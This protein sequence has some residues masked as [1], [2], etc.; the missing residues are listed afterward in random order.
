MV[1]VM[2]AIMILALAILPMAGMFDTALRAAVLG[3]N[4]DKARA[5]ANEKLEEALA[6]PYREPGGGSDSVI[7]VPAGVSVHRYRGDIHLHRADEVPRRRLL[8]PEQLVPDVADAGRSRGPVARVV[9]HHRR[10]RRRRVA[11]RDEDGFTFPE[12]LVATTLM[13]V[14]LFALYSIFDM[15]IRVF[16]FGNDKTEAVENARLGLERMEREIKGSIPL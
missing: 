1:E 7:E 16:S 6:L 13:V 15:S 10:V 4:Y 14:V 12:V 2:A 8:H 11:L 3:G 9:V 5:L